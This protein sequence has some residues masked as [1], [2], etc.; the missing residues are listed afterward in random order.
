MNFSGIKQSLANIDYS[1]N[2]AQTYLVLVP[3]L[4]LVIRKIQLANVL[5]L[6]NNVLP[7]QM[8]NFALA[9][10]DTS[11]RKF[12]RICGS[13]LL[14]STIQLIAIYAAGVFVSPLFFLLAIPSLY[15]MIDSAKLGLK[16]VMTYKPQANGGYTVV[17]GSALGAFLGS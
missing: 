1:L 3:G 11:S 17:I 15:E 6:I 14:G 4:S 7:N 9:P 16:T 8:Q 5:P 10:A 12:A 2:K 13:H